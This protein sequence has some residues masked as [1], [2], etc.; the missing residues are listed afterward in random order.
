MKH[1]PVDMALEVPPSPLFPTTPRTLGHEYTSST[2]LHDLSPQKIRRAS[3]GHVSHKRS[4]SYD[5]PSQINSY[6]E[7]E[8]SSQPALSPDYAGNRSYE[9]VSPTDDLHLALKSIQISIGEHTKSTVGS[10]WVPI[11]APRPPKQPSKLPS[12]HKTA[13]IQSISPLFKGFAG[14]RK[15]KE[16]QTARQDDFEESRGYFDQKGISKPIHSGISRPHSD[17]FPLRVSTAH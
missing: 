3:V 8:T 2:N 9:I 6:D 12:F 14:E 17:H 11:R 5:F 16:P 10:Y 13:I 7:F 1:L 4:A 15:P